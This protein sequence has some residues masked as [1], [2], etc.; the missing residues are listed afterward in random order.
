MNK[1]ILIGIMLII[2]T[3]NLHSSIWIVDE[4]NFPAMTNDWRSPTW[5]YI[6]RH[7]DG[8]VLHRHWTSPFFI[9]VKRP[10]VRLLMDQVVISKKVMDGYF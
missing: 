8:R 9:L 1:I 7:D 2:V 3:L 10:Y 6:Y 4:R 5:A